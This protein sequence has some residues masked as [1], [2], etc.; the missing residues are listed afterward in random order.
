M[1]Q[2]IVKTTTSRHIIHMITT[3]RP[4]EV[5]SRRV[6]VLREI[7]MITLKHNLPQSSLIEI[8]GIATELIP[9]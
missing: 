8:V 6:Y 7:H 1:I 3:S 5:S 2:L 4:V 9:M